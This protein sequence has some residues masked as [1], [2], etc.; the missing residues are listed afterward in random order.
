MDI[1][2]VEFKIGH[3]VINYRRLSGQ[4]KSRR[5]SW[6]FAVSFRS[7][8][9]LFPSR[10]FLSLVSSSPPVC[11]RLV[12]FIFK[13]RS[14][15]SAV[16]LCHGNYTSPPTLQKAL[17]SPMFRTTESV[18][19]PSSWTLFLFPESN[20]FHTEGRSPTVVQAWDRALS[21]SLLASRCLRLRC[22][23]WSLKSHSWP[24]TWRRLNR[25]SGCRS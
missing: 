20:R 12:P 22:W 15:F 10:T 4:S 14:W 19:G 24:H 2:W 18:R 11:T 17:C 8:N 9:S 23:N 3:E 13:W 7:E 25:W 16:L 6:S 5:I 21:V 1:I